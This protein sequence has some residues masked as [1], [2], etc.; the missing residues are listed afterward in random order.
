MQS[1]KVSA[2]VVSV[3]GLCLASPALTAHD[4]DDDNTPA[5]ITVAFGTGNNNAQPNNTPNHHVLPRE[6]TVRITKARKLSGEV[7]SVPATVNF[8][9]SGFHWIWAYQPGV[10]LQEVVDHIPAAGTFVNYEVITGGVSNV[11]AKGIFPGTPTA[12]PPFSDAMPFPFGATQNRTD[13][14]A[15][16]TPG[17]YLVICNVRGHLI[18]GMY[19]WVRVVDDDDDHDHDGHHGDH[20]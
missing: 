9:V 1:V 6:V 7:V 15:F 18:D 20:H 4:R 5:S 12:V 3:L 8:I 10:K 14:I 2:I 17:R 19:S 13:S 16:A 11:Y